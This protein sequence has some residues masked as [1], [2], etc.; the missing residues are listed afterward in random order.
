MSSR[1]QIIGT[2]GPASGTPDLLARMITAGMDA[3]RL[4]F[5]HGTYA[6]HDAYIVAIRNAARAAGKHIP[7]IQDLSGPR[8]GIA[9]GHQY[10]GKKEIITEKDIKDLAFGLERDIAYI[11]QSYIGCAADVGLLRSLIFKAGKKTPIIAKIERKEAVKHFDEILAVSD[12]IMIARGDLGLAEP[13][14]EIPFIQMDLIARANRAGKPVITATQML[15]SMTGSPTPT[16][17]EVTDVAFA[18][19]TG[20]D[21]IM[22]SEETALGKFPVEAVATMEKIASRAETSSRDKTRNR[23]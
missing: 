2:I 9:G 12:A 10:D 21:A 6:K 1:T 16:R 19:L 23:L 11:A 20:S 22:L 13:I 4:N 5:S 7:I 18:V 3:A 8:T 17:A 14:E 15:L